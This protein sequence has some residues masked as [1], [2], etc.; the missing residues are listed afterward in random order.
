MLSEFLMCPPFRVTEATVR[1]KLR[2][3]L[4]RVSRHATVITRRQLEERRQRLGRRISAFHSKASAVMGDFDLNALGL[5]EDDV[6]RADVIPGS[7][8]DD[9]D[10]EENDDP[11][12]E[13]QWEDDDS[14]H[15]EGVVEYPEKL[16]L[17]LPST[18]GGDNIA[19]DDIG[20]LAGLELELRKGQANDCLEGLRLALGHKSLLFRTRIRQAGTNKERTKA[21]DDVKT[22]RRQVE[23]HVRGYHRARAAMERLGAGEELLSHYRRIERKDLSTSGDI[24]DENRLGQR[25]DRLAWFWS[26]RTPADESNPW[27]NE[28]MLLLGVR[29]V[30]L[31]AD[32]SLLQFIE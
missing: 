31:I 22:A 1:D 21:W 15:G 25:N 28:C 30:L 13:P 20:Q 5:S 2:W 29:L 16:P 7:G 17:L 18:L 3:E 32:L 11:D 8:V 26:V 14:D 19:C 4:R 9:S 12:M 23:K 27:M 24:T 6:E 10:G